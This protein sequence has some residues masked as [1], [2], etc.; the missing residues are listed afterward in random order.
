M[1]VVTRAAGR[2]LDPDAAAAAIASFVVAQDITERRHEFGASP[3]P[4][5]WSDLPAKTLG[6][7]FDT[8]CPIGPALVALDDLDDPTM[9]TKRCWINGRLTF[10]HSTADMLWSAVDLVSLVSSFMT[11]PVRRVVSPL[12][13]R[14]LLSLT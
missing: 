2:H 9:L 4:W 8:F 6:K 7:S 10:E 11:L 3:P 1:G 13:G 14:L 12:P 5:S